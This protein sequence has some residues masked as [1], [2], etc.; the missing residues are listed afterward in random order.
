M[1]PITYR[2]DAEDRLCA[3]NEEWDRFARDNGA[4]GLAGGG[5]LG[6]PLWDFITDAATAHLYRRLLE[7]ARQGRES[8]F[9]FRCD[10]PDRKRWLRMTMS[11]AGDGGVDFAVDA[12]RVETRPP[13][14]AL[15]AG[16]ARA[17]EAVKLCGWCKRFP[18][19]REWLEAEDAVPR[20]GLMGEGTA[21]PLT[22]GLC[23]ECEAR[24]NAE[25]E[26][27]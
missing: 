14:A 12:V 19:G 6:R 4:P 10:S 20:L 16:C 7:R 13:L 9:G 1:N 3:V 18:V 21:P 2:V 24:M 23:P 25:L 5:A 11:P 26:R 22:H 8:S 27:A 15:D 17:G